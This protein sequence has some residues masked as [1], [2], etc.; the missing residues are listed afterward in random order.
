MSDSIVVCKTLDIGIKQIDDVEYVIIDSPTL[1]ASKI[2]FQIKSAFPMSKIVALDYFQGLHDIDYRISIFDQQS[3][4]F[5]SNSETHLVGLE[6]AVLSES[7][8]LISS[9]A[10]S[11]ERN[12]NILIKFSGGNMNILDVVLQNTTKVF[13]ETAFKIVALNNS[14][15]NVAI[16]QFKRQEEFLSLLH[17]CSLYI[18]SGVTTLLECSILKTP[19]IFI[20]SNELERNF[21]SALSI[22][23]PLRFLNST[24]VDF[25]KQ[26]VKS[27]HD[28]LR[29]EGGSHFIPRLSVDMSGAKRIVDSVVNL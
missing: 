8:N 25:E 22:E 18:G 21:V 2:A 29:S 13:R 4:S 1:L 23:K 20:G 6:Y 27:L 16:P 28:F 10:D 5:K 7:V 11:T 17:G 9:K 15:I 26:L 19:C 3:F 12:A 24:S 14:D